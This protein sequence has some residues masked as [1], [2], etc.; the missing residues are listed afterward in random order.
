MK[1]GQLTILEGACNIE[2]PTEVC[3]KG[4]LL[5]YNNN[6]TVCFEDLETFD[7]ADDK[8]HLWDE[9]GRYATIYS[10][11]LVGDDLYYSVSNAEDK[12]HG[13][14]GLWVYNLKNKKKQQIRK[15]KP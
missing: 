14:E 6:S 11:F 10:M 15:A 4:S 13:I 12:Y 9:R 8:I 2:P 5:I 3:K 1:T 7:F